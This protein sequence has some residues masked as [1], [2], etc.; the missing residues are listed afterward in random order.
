MHSPSFTPRQINGWNIIMEAWK[1]IFLSKWVICRCKAIPFLH[2]CNL[3]TSLQVLHWWWPCWVCG[4]LARWGSWVLG[5]AHPANLRYSTMFFIVFFILH[6][7]YDLLL[8]WKLLTKT[9]FIRFF[10]CFTLQAP[11][12]LQYGMLYAYLYFGSQSSPVG[13]GLW[14]NWEIKPQ[15]YVPLEPSFP[16]QRLRFMLEDSQV[17]PTAPLGG[18]FLRVDS[19][20]QNKTPWSLQLNPLR[21]QGTG[22][23]KHLW[24]FHI[25]AIFVKQL[26]S[27]TWS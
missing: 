10:S 22:G 3:E 5:A 1:I 9:S 15:A 25:S 23:R 17:L 18:R 13:P 2:P 7:R 11:V 6:L 12:E 8:F 26:L 24:Q 20:Q 27:D 14:S 19:L 16:L 21:V 4:V